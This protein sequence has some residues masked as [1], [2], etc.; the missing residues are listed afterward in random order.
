MAISGIHQIACFSSICPLRYYEQLTR[1]VRL[2]IVS[3]ELIDFGGGVIVVT[4]LAFGNDLLRMHAFLSSQSR[5]VGLRYGCHERNSRFL[6]CA[7]GWREG[8]SSYCNV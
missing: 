2:D 4:M 5:L 6:L 7:F 1:G 8:F 3:P